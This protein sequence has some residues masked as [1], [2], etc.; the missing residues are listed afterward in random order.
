MNKQ[1]AAPASVRAHARGT[2]QSGMREH[3]ERLV[4]S[5]LRQ[6]GSLAKSDIARM[7]GLSAQTISVIMRKLEADALLVRK[8]PV[9]GR[10]GQP[11]VPM[12][13]N[14]RGAYFLGLKIGRRSADLVLIDFLGTVC[15][16]RRRSYAYPTPART[17]AFVT[18]AL[19]ELRAQLSPEQER[20]IAG[21]G[22]AMPFQLWSWTEAV[23]A[24]PCAM[25]AWRHCDIRGAIA[26]HVSFPVYLQNDA[27]AACGAELVLGTGAPMREFLYFYIGAFIG[28]GVVL[29][30]T[31]YAGRSGNAGALGS[32]PVPVRGGSARQLI[33]LASLTTLERGLVRRGLDASFLWS[34]PETWARI[35][36]D[37]APWL[38]G[39]AKALAHAVAA[40][41]A[42]VEFEAA[43]IDGWMPRAVLDRLCA[44]T[45]HHL[46]TIDASGMRVPPIRRG[47]VGVHAR[48]LGGAC[49]PL[50]QRY[51]L[52]HDAARAQE[53]P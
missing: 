34:A 43:V 45:Q 21:L 15:A 17:V 25:D 8:A 24:P 33:E 36:Q 48:V 12:A 32:M 40:A 5:L 22:I 4:L 10:I 44:R 49:L 26:A 30:G 37:L 27:T 50:A 47:T 2:N 35:D 42:V 41:S 6:H 16:M 29:D 14:P 1:H 7:T 3:N 11:S 18:D 19:G 23:G 39:A 51:L 20:K 53:M 31:L 9:R 38:E 28:G 46:G 52:P 13:L